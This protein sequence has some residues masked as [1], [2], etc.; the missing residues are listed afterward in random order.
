MSKIEQYRSEMERIQELSILDTIGLVD[1]AHLC[2]LDTQDGRGDSK[3]LYGTANQ[4]LGIVAKLESILNKTVPISAT[5]TEDEADKARE[6]EAKK[7]LYKVS[8]DYTS[9]KNKKAHRES[10]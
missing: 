1:R 7:I 3:W 8:K 4:A 6:D 9:Y 2:D 5:N 10:K